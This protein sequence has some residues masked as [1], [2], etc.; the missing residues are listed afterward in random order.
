MINFCF[1]YV[2]EWKNCGLIDEIVIAKEGQFEKIAKGV[3][4]QIMK[5][6]QKQHFQVHRC[7]L[8]VEYPEGWN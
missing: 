1:E 7:K 6:M 2:E 5:K 3:S 8:E 4:E